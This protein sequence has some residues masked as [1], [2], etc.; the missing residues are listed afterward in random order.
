MSDRLTTPNP[1]GLPDGRWRLE[2]WVG[3]SLRASATALIGVDAQAPKVTAQDPAFG[4]TATSGRA[5]A[6]PVAAGSNQVLLFFNY[7]GMEEAHQVRWLVF[8]NGQ[9]IY[10]SPELPWTGGGSGKWWV[11]YKDD[12]PLTGGTW[13]FELHVDGQVVL[14]KEIG[15]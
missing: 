2:V 15:L 14:T 13:E 6:Q 9:A 5:A 3:G 12:A 10:Q 8:H 4:S 11:G 7:E 1:A